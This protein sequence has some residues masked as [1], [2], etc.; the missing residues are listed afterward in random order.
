MEA[1]WPAAVAKGANAA[2]AFRQ[3][4]QRILANAR[5]GSLADPS[6]AHLHAYL[7]SAGWDTA[8]FTPI[9]Y[10]GRSLGILA[11]YH[12]AEPALTEPQLAL[13]RALAGQAAVAIEN[14]NLLYQAQEKASLEER[15]RL[16]REL[17]DSVSQALY[18]IA[19]GAKTA[20]SMLERDP[21][22]AA[23]PLDYVLALANAGLTEMR[24]LIFELRPESLEQEGIVIALEK[25]AGALR[26]RHKLQ[27]ETDLGAEPVAPLEV[28]QA[29]FRIAQEA[30]HNI[31]KHARATSVSIVLASGADGL[32]LEVRDD[33]VGFDPSEA[34]PGH[35]G[36]RSIRERATRLGGH[37]EVSSAPGAGTRIIAWAPVRTQTQESAAGSRERTATAPSRASGGA[38]LA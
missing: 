2:L 4:E 30:L 21:A 17:H 32:T 35:F 34:Y 8:V 38:P 6:V 28:K 7:R 10:R 24:A 5:A 1:R 13:L 16:A 27:V 23:E 36:L 14:A 37:A 26:S 12:P 31:V 33:G 11:S 3:Q 29:L 9:V 15:Q 18:G 19:L 25:Q 20:R 22:R